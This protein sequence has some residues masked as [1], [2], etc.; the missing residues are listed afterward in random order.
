MK[1]T[2]VKH[3]QKAQTCRKCG[4]RIKPSRDEKRVVE[5]KRTGKK[6][7]KTVRVLGDSYRWIKFNRCEKTVR[8][9]DN[10]CRFRP[11]DLT[12]SDKLSQLY[13]AQENAEDSVDLWDG[14][15][16]SVDDLKSAMEDLQNT[17][18]EVS[19]AYGESADNIEQVFTGGSTT[20]EECRE[21]SEN[22]ESWKND[23]ENI[24]FDEWDGPAEGEELKCSECEQTI[25]HDEKADTFSHD[26]GDEEKDAKQ[27]ADH[28]AEPAERKNSAGQTFE[29]WVEA[30]KDIALEAIGNCP[31]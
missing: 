31:I 18:E 8:C 22:L 5:N 28:D 14:E 16:D 9:M 20:A 6:V 1:I 2:E 30:Q 25:E 24:D 12:S 23:L 29:E 27:D 7:K 17:V 4:A 11:S 21:K 10:S 15:G 3:A 19:A 26:T 13:G